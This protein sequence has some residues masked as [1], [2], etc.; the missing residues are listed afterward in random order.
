MERARDFILGACAVVVCMLLS[1]WW[2]IVHKGKDP[3][4]HD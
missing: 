1:I 2:M 3:D 4:E